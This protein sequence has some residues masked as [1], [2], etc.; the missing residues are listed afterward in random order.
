MQ[1]MS[2]FTRKPSEVSNAHAEMGVFTRETLQTQ[3][4]TQTQIDRHTSF[5]RSTIVWIPINFLPN[6]W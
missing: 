4:Q 3:T 2:V 5:P 6:V 1:E